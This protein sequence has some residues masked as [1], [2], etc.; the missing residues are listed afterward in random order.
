MNFSIRRE[1]FI[2]GQTENARSNAGLV[3]VRQS[4]EE[5]LLDRLTETSYPRT[6]FVTPIIYMIYLCRKVK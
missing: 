1:D 4:Q 3:L 5:A 2:V 6:K